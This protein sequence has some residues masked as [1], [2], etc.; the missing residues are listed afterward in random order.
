MDYNYY[1]YSPKM[2]FKWNISSTGPSS[3]HFL[4]D[5]EHYQNISQGNEEV[6]QIL[7]IES[8]GFKSIEGIEI[9]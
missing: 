9:Q 2:D 6:L 7:N 4:L 1:E 3:I 5:F 8:T